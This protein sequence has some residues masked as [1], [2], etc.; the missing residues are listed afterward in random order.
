M[1]KVLDSRPRF[2]ASPMTPYLSEI[3]ETSLLGAEEERDLALRVRAGDVTAR[4]HMVRANLRLVV[5]I[6]RTFAGRGLGLEDL[7]QEGNLG[8][9]RAVEG[10]D[11][12]MGTRFVTYACFWIRQSMQRALDNMAMT[13]RIPSYAVDLVTSWRRKAV[14]LH[15]QL[16]RTPTEEEVARALKL[17]KKTLKIVQKALRIYNGDKQTDT[18]AGEGSF[19]D[20]I[21]DPTSIAPDDRLTAAEEVRQVLDLVDRLEAREATI[22]R[23]RFG[24]HGEDPLTLNQV[25]ERLGLTRERVRQLER[26][27]LAKL[28]EMI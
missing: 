11:P 2:A 23:L 27:A 24:L 18:A 7:I 22:L 5:R 17:T 26:G 3:N 9:V 19:A 13:I 25:G 12:E 16:G 21:G 1:T 28:K 8:L 4:D 20:S 6:A 14:E 10:F 15:Q